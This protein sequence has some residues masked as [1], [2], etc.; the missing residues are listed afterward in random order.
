[1]FK[2]LNN[3]IA[4]DVFWDPLRRYMLSTDG[5]IFRVM[6]A[7]VVYPRCASDVL[8]VVDFGRAHSLSVHSRGAGSG[9]CGAAL[10]SGIVVDFTRYMNRLICLDVENKT[11]TCEPG[12]RLGELEVVL[13]DKGLFFPPDPSSGEYASFGGMYG[14]NASGSHSVKYGNT[15][16]YIID[17]DLVFSTGQVST[18]SEISETPYEH[19]PENLKSLWDL[20]QKHADTIESA[21][22]PVRFNTAGYNLRGL[23]RNGR[24]NMARLLAGSEGTLA[25]V[26]RL[27]FRLI[28]KPVFDSLVV[29]F[30]DDILSSA[31]AVADILPLNPSGIEIMDRSLLRLAG[32]HDERLKKAVPE[33]VDNVLLIEFDG[34]D[35][36]GCA[37]AA[38]NAAG[39][40]RS[41]G[42]SSRLH[43]AASS[44]E[45]AAFWAV[46][47]AA[48][49]ILYKLKGEKKILALIEDAA[50]PVDRLVDYFKG[51]Y[52]MLK[53]FGVA[54]VTY[55]HIAKGLLHT[56]PLLNLK[57]P[58]DVSLLRPIA[59]AL[60]DLVHSLGGSVSG[61]H[62]DGRLRSAYIQRQY[63][64]IYPLFRQVKD[65]LDPS[66][67][68]NP[69]II[70]CHD[71]DQMAKSL[72]FGLSY[73]L[74]E[75]INFFL[76][77]PEGGIQEIEK[78]H[79][80]GK[81]TTVTPAT[82]MCPV[83][84]ATRDEA[85]APKAKANILR[86]LIS[87]AI[88]DQSVYESAFQHVI[89]HCANCGS[90][91]Q[92]CPSS[93]NIPKMCME[94]RAAYTETFGPSLT[95]RALSSVEQTARIAEKIPAVFNTLSSLPLVRKTAERFAGISS[96]RP[97]RFSPG[98][99]RRHVPFCSGRGPI[100]VLYFTGCYAAW[101][102]PAIAQAA[103]K[104]LTRMGMTVYTPDQHCCGLPMLSKGM[105]SQTRKKIAANLEKWEKIL[106]IADYIT[107]TCS[108]CGYAL[109]KDWAYAADG[110]AIRMVQEKM[111][112]ITRLISLY[113]DRLPLIPGT[114]RIAYHAP[115]HLKIQ[116]YPECSLHLLRR[117]PG[118]E[119]QDLNS[120]C[121][122]MIGTWGMTTRN[123]GL[124]QA[125]SSGMIENLN[126]FAA[127]VQT[128]QGSK[129][130]DVLR[131]CFGVTDC[132]T[133]RMQMQ[134]FSNKPIRHPV[135]ILAGLP[136]GDRPI[137]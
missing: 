16:D 124:S 113:F 21:Y 109:M 79:G 58:K 107:V 81:C 100:K 72:R 127:P 24:L 10:G 36:A 69:D 31:R 59:D 53:R 114:G 65:L 84:K 95:D 98:P 50:V 22:P 35:P 91:V 68:L 5:S 23:V 43:A 71:P 134:Q 27:T 82:R 45:K 83:Y 129:T 74:I 66:H 86:A 103:V 54:F 119:V 47:K 92:E 126:R 132:P 41:R 1:L 135:E 137:Y 17:A 70:T 131:N 108:S 3:Q 62:G 25:L 56:R 78:C 12:F 46:R 87:G 28:D 2:E 88:S 9:L 26:T 52:A 112:H 38:Q 15:A 32:S 121:C 42:Y 76:N 118:L 44:G 97:V 90:C 55:G 30:M 73:P 133:C 40:I 89:G 125:I 111:I 116:P 136:A 106:R 117:I 7:A 63:P 96:R 49:P 102:E 18:L 34:F 120:N 19:L 130:S 6:P 48:V 8:A 13:K 77:W 33:D 115:C 57:D 67:L 37:Q 11:F 20:Y 104:V 61:E 64:A 51:I 4:G 128:S 75:N 14:T 110:P 93:V 105:V 101:I 85:A 80:C 122:G 29:A 99:L 123:Y 39:L 60:F 94:A